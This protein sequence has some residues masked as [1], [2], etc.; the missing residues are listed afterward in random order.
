MLPATTRPIF[1]SI[2]ADTVLAPSFS[3]FRWSAMLRWAC[4]TTSDSSLVV[5]D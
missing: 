5:T 1:T 3:S 4:T 2:A